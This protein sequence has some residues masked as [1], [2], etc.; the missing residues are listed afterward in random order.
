MSSST[1]FRALAGF[2]EPELILR[3][4]V[5][6]QSPPR[7]KPSVIAMVRNWT[8]HVV[9]PSIWKAAAPRE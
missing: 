2:N 7:P 8:E 3:K 6:E 4:Y 1:G 9:D 5:L